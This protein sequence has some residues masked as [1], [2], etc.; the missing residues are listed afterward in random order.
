M[1]PS[2]AAPVMASMAMADLAARQ[3][4][5]QKQITET[6]TQIAANEDGYN[7]QEM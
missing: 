6:L 3:T 5:Y 2:E 7:F 4:R 1:Y